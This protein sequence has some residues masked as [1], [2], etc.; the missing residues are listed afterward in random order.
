MA[1]EVR[2]GYKVGGI[3][4]TVVG[5]GRVLIQTLHVLEIEINQLSLWNRIPVIIFRNTFLTFGILNIESILIPDMETLH[6]D[7]VNT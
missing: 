3:G 1:I 2:V 7:A 4:F 6:P 5:L